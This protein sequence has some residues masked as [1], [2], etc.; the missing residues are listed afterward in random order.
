MSR[1]R[2]RGRRVKGGH[3]VFSHHGGHSASSMSKSRTRTRT[4]TRTRG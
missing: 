1:G 4:R 2:G 3:K